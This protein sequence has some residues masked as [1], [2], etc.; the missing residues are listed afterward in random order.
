MLKK[1]TYEELLKQNVELSNELKQLK[2]ENTSDQKKCEEIQ[3]EVLK[4]DLKLTH[5]NTAL[6]NLNT[7]VYIKDMN[8]R[9]LYANKKCLTLFNC[10]AHEL[11]SL[12]D[13][14]FF[15][16]TT[17]DQIK[18]IESEV[19]NYGKD[20]ENEVDTTDHNGNRK[21]YWEIKT[22][23]YDDK[24]QNK[25]I[26][27]CGVS[28][29]ITYRKIAEESI[30]ENQLQL[31]HLNATKDKIFSIIAH[32]LRSP[33]NHIIGFSELMLE[34]STNKDH[35]QD[36]DCIKIINSTAKN[37]L[38]LLDNL[39]NWAYTE[40]GKL[41][42]R[43]ENINITNIITQVVDFKT[44]IAQAKNITITYNAVQDIEFYTDSNLLKTVLR[45]LISNAIKFT[46]PNGSINITALQ[47]DKFLEI[48]VIDTGVGM[49]TEHMTDLFNL[50]T[51]KSQPGT[52]GEKGSGLGLILCKEFVEKMHGT[53]WVESVVNKGSTFKFSLPI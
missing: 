37:T 22:P 29:D 19:I 38:N 9:Y 30:K 49:S 25:V 24:H 52:E 44:S 40:T 7:Y 3:L 16:P 10:S 28:T 36:S 34:N 27:L 39:L 14:D 21:V 17:C 20:T 41:S 2:L 31:K 53:L 23:I 48:A 33:F 46:N 1:P 35:S 8:G 5:L 42:Y 13:A 26:G 32:D 12:S 6:D 43:P 45:N 4:A 50:T 11:S 47:K 51:H 15:P 18:I